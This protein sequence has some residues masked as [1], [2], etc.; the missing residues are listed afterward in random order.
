MNTSAII[1]MFLSVGI[2]SFFTIRYF[3]LALKMPEKKQASSENK[4]DLM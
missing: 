2:V 4:A 3:W 1:M